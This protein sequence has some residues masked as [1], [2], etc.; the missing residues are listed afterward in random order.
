MSRK[1]ARD[2]SFKCIYQIEYDTEN[3]IE[4]LITNNLEDVNIQSEDNEYVVLLVKGVK[5]N[6]EVID[7]KIKSNLKD[8]TMDRISK[9]DLAILRLAIY[10]ILYIE[11]LS[12]KIS[13]NEAVE[14]AKTYSDDKSPKFINGVIASVIAKV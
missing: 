14:L 9:V 11:D 3:D 10:E 6:I 8:W 13:A 12:N 7:E 1:K 2:I 5:E 4:K